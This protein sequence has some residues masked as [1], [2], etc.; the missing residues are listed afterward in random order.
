MASAGAGSDATA[1]PDLPDELWCAIAAF[2]VSYHE[3]GRMASVS[4]G[5]RRAVRS[6]RR[7]R[8]LAYEP[9][10]PNTS[11]ATWRAAF[12]RATECN[13]SKRVS[14]VR[15][16]AEC[17]ELAH[18]CWIT[19]SNRI[20]DEIQVGA[21][22]DLASITSLI[23]MEE[24]RVEF[25]AA[26]FTALPNLTELNVSGCKQRELTDAFRPL[27]ALQRLSVV[28]CRQLTDEA[29]RPLASLTSLDMG[30]CAFTNEGLM[31]LESLTSLDVRWCSQ[32]ALTDA[33][34]APLKS[35][36]SLNISGCRQFTNAAFAHLTGLTLFDMSGC[37]QLSIT[38]GRF[39]RLTSLTELRLR[40]SFQLTDAAFGSLA[41]LTSLT[42]LDLA[43]C[44]QLTNAAFERLASL[45]SLTSLEL[46]T[47]RQAG[48]TDAA[49][50]R[51]TSLKT[52]GISS[53]PQF[54]DAGLA[55]LTSLTE[56]NCAGCHL[57]TDA[58]FAPLASLRWLNGRFWDRRSRCRD[59]ESEK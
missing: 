48:I 34:F 21:G 12:P 33:A 9:V 13:L 15:S 14:A 31:R 44:S 30:A 22:A 37:H 29:L 8:V 17:A 57:L 52:L 45:V 53:C 43:G 4:K 56:L 40:H 50:K 7:H 38:D 1:A 54:T 10:P 55:P 39:G 27:T 2:L 58:A 49:L 35:L 41:P 51:L 28:G 24:H 42:L 46:G 20:W 11:L 6:L 23:M 5:A 59:G 25:N 47:C 19:S 32:A 18:A 26:S 36:R 3:L 16:F